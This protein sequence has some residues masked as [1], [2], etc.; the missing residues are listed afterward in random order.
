MFLYICEIAITQNKFKVV[1]LPLMRISPKS[2]TYELILR[3]V[4]DN[5][6]TILLSTSLKMRM[7]FAQ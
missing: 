7:F 1:K 2:C 6:V 4:L 3:L 5:N